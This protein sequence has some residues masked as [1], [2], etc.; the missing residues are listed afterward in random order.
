MPGFAN[1]QKTAQPESRAAKSGRSPST[2]GEA[3]LLL[4]L[5][6][7]IGNQAVHRLL[8]SSAGTTPLAYPLAPLIQRK[9]SCN[10]SGA[11]CGACAA[12]EQ[13][14]LQ[15]KAAGT[16]DGQERLTVNSPDDKYEHEADRIADGISSPHEHRATSRESLQIQ[17]FSPAKGAAGPVPASVSRALADRGS[18]LEPAVLHSMED[19]FGHDFSAVRVHSGASA[20][21]SAADI[22]ADAYTVGRD[23]V[24]AEGK[25]APDTRQG[26]RLLAHEL[27]HV[28]QQGE[29]ASSIQRAPASG[30]S[31]KDACKY[32]PG[33]VEKSRS[34]KGIL[35]TDVAIASFYNI[36]PPD[37]TVVVDFEVG[38][39]ELRSGA[40]G[41]LRSQWKDLGEAVFPQEILGYS[42]CVGPEK[43]NLQLRKDRAASVARIMSRSTWASEA[44]A[45][46]A[47]GD[48]PAYLAGNDS[49]EGRALN[50]GVVIR[51]PS[52]CHIKDP[53]AFIYFEH[54]D[55]YK[56]PHDPR[57]VESTACLL[58]AYSRLSPAAAVQ[59]A[60]DLMQRKGLYQFYRPLPEPIRKQIAR[61]LANVL[62]R[63]DTETYAARILGAEV[64]TPYGDDP[65]KIPKIVTSIVTVD[66]T[67]AVEMTL[68]L[69]VLAVPVVDLLGA[70]ECTDYTFGFTQFETV[71]TNV[72]EFYNPK[73]NTYLTI[74]SG[75]RWKPF[76]PCQ[77][78]ETD[79]DI[80]TYSSKLECKSVDAIKRLPAVPLLHFEDIPTTPFLPGLPDGSILKAARSFRRFVTIFSVM[81]PNGAVKN[82]SW[83][84]W[85][86]EYCEEYPLLKL[87]SG[88]KAGPGAASGRN[89]QV[90]GIHEGSPPFDF[91]KRVGTPSGRSCNSLRSE[92]SVSTLGTQPTI[93]CGTP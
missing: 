9:C 38:H 91:A 3:N 87:G 82:L 80:W 27:T 36:D 88:P 4:Q 90:S 78:V 51:R 66:G 11:K 64:R 67:P 44:A 61:I 89:V 14:S 47:S 39:S 6:R 58:E 13:H 59:V 32:E 17:R 31:A 49:K 28:V 30:D 15:L 93:K 56:D 41:L 1:K 22:N 20:G 85:R 81:F 16:A 92:K 35:D 83:F 10:G 73:N 24:F 46:A 50:R 63:Q 21:Q 75:A 74:D 76:L 57:A 5:Q 33:E 7:S 19:H 34:P 69:P 2:P 42:D 60:Q 45:R 77:D 65:A 53:K 55:Q 54:P 62:G 86:M 40:A 79:G 25:Y 8:R 29:A 70:S 71:K 23:V 68:E 48:D 72:S 26:R 12:D 18:P 37:A 52:G 84:E 43:D